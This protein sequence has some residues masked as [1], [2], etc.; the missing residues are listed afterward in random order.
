MGRLRRV[1]VAVVVVIATVV[2]VAVGADGTRLPG[3]I[4]IGVLA[5]GS[6]FPSTELLQEVIEQ[7]SHGQW[8]IREAAHMGR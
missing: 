4:G 1:I 2:V 5:A 7:V 3:S 8:S 6:G